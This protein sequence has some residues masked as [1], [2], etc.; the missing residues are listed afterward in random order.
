RLTSLLHSKKQEFS[1]RYYLPRRVLALLL[2]GIFVV[3]VA[4]LSL[5]ALIALVGTG[6][7]GPK[8]S[9]LWLVLALLPTL[10]SVLGLLGHAQ[11]H[12][13]GQ[14]YQGPVDLKWLFVA[15][16]LMG[17]LALRSWFRF[18]KQVSQMA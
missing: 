10:V 18:S 7:C 6:K 11:F 3:V 15:P 12:F 17:V 14:S 8:R 2:V 9:T 13:A 1:A 5:S 16:G 4:L